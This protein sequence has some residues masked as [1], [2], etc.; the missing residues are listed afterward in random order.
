LFP[1]R[2]EYQLLLINFRSPRRPSDLEKGKQRE[3][4]SGRSDEVDFFNSRGGNAFRSVDSS[5]SFGSPN[6]GSQLDSPH[7]RS[8]PLTYTPTTSTTVL[9]HP[10]SEHKPYNLTRESS[11]SYV[12][13]VIQGPP[14]P[15][16]RVPAEIY[17]LKRDSQLTSQRGSSQL[18]INRNSHRTPT[19][20]S[21]A[22]SFAPSFEVPQSPRTYNSHNSH[23]SLRSSRSLEFSSVVELQ[24]KPTFRVSAKIMDSQV[25]PVSTAKMPANARGPSK[26]GPSD[27][28]RGR[29]SV[30]GTPMDSRKG[31]PMG[32]RMGSPRGSRMGSPRDSRR[33]TPMGSRSGSPVGSRSNSPAPLSPWSKKTCSQSAENLALPLPAPTLAGP[34]RPFSDYKS[35]LARPP[36]INNS[37]DRSSAPVGFDAKARWSSANGH[38]RRPRS[39]HKHSSSISPAGSASSNYFDPSAK[40]GA[41]VPSDLNP[42]SEARSHRGSIINFSRP[43][44]AG[45]DIRAPPV[46]A[47]KVSTPHGSN[48]RH[49]NHDDLDSGFSSGGK[50]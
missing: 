20:V 21:T 28:E 7:P 46:P 44:T 18:D 47:L 9:T 30:R 22:P 5:T 40:G 36:L 24:E 49:S 8:K 25:R 10:M 50:F 41:I 1:S 39:S 13:S 27:H 45:S 35:P 33:G 17:D 16:I 42:F 12:E 37:Q 32:S 29:M 15:G 38:N 23:Y 3:I 34:S 48:A 6:L 14:S 43:T 19:R 4:S 11:N 26:L 31:S 2:T